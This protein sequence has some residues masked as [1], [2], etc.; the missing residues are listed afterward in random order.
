MNGELLTLTDSSQ[1]VLSPDALLSI[2]KDQQLVVNLYTDSGEWAV[3]SSLVSSTVVVPAP[4]S[5][6]VIRIT[7]T[8]SYGDCVLPT[9]TSPTAVDANK[10]SVLDPSDAAA[11]GLVR[12]EAF[13]AVGGT[14]EEF[15]RYDDDN[16]LYLDQGEMAAWHKASV[17]AITGMSQDPES[18]TQFVKHA[19]LFAQE[20]DKLRE[21]QQKVETVKRWW[22]L[23]KSLLCLLLYYTFGIVYYH[24]KEG[25]TKVDSMY[26]VTV[27][28]TTVGYGDLRPSSDSS[29]LVTCAYV[30]VGFL[31]LGTAFGLI[32]NSALE[33]LDRGAHELAMLSSATRATPESPKSPKSKAREEKAERAVESKDNSKRKC[34]W[35]LLYLSVCIFGGALFYAVVES[36]H[37]DFLHAFYMALMTAT[38][39]GLGDNSPRSQGGRVFATFWIVASVMVAAKGVADMMSYYVLR[40]EQRREKRQLKMCISLD[41]L[42]T[43]GGEDGKLDKNEFLVCKLKGMGRISQVDVDNCYEAFSQWDL[44]GDGYIDRSE[45]LQHSLSQIRIQ[46]EENQTKMRKF[47]E[48][49]STWHLFCPKGV[50]DEIT[51]CCSK[52]EPTH[53]LSQPSLAKSD[54]E[55]VNSGRSVG[56]NEFYNENVKTAP[57]PDTDV[58]AAIN[59]KSL[60]ILSDEKAGLDGIDGVSSSQRTN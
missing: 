50:P 30:V 32:A 16:N 10:L 18:L 54:H 60:S 28:L 46:R 48:F 11:D 43:Y 52:S 7:R 8:A 21:E 39:V 41:D 38:T 35:N 36:D 9:I 47:T 24:I 51:K 19:T 25:W 57:P 22:R 26:F 45:I 13:L 29:V 56:I 53:S 23:G 31:L 27:T 6:F 40:N 5:G 59:E 1:L 15:A 17:D 12:K 4:A 20:A 34:Y 14:E 2:A 58:L 44:G 55:D 42:D 33:A 49:G 37:Y 3:D